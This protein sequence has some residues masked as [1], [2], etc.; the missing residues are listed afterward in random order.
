MINI[1]KA[2][3]VFLR[4][5]ENYDIND[6]KIAL[7]RNHILRVSQIS[8]K[9]AE[10]LNLSQED[11]ELAELIGLLH[12]IGRFEQVKKYN[13]F[14]DKI[15]INHGEYGVKILFE[16]NLI[17][18]FGIEEKYYKIIKTAILNHNRA[19]I[20]NGLS[21]K[22]LLHSKIIRDSDKIDIFYV[23]MTDS[24]E[25]IYGCKTLQNAKFSDDI[26]KEV[27]EN[28]FIDYKNMKEYGDIWIAHIAY[29]FDLYYKSSYVIIKNNDY[30]NKLL[31]K[32][33]FKNENTINQANEIVKI[34]NKYID[35]KIKA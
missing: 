12:D 24:M 2:K 20:E 10:S 25:N 15:S 28:Y 3:N 9:I 4:Y 11:I 23:L 8:K 32:A 6:G 13:T 16:E 5:V 35:E 26:I 21:E 17:K 29:V 27:E 14:L 34:A 7:K 1:E 18:E 30:I 33:D 19:K 31:E 22:E